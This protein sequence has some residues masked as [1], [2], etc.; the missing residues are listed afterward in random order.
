[1][2]DDDFFDNPLP[3]V[4]NEE[5]DLTISSKAMFGIEIGYLNFESS[6]KHIDKVN[7]RE[8]TIV[9]TGRGQDISLV[10]VFENSNFM[11]KI[12]V[13]S[14]SEEPI[15]SA[16]EMG[17]SEDI[18]SPKSES[19]THTEIGYNFNFNKNEGFYFSIFGDIGIYS[20]EYK[21]Q[22]LENL[23]DSSDYLMY[24]DDFKGDTFD[25]NTQSED[26]ETNSDF[27]LD[28][29]AALNYEVKNF[30]FQ[31]IGKMNTMEVKKY[32]GI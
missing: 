11:W 24:I 20:Y 30:K 19:I 3:E 13:I 12:G 27:F 22:N 18:W 16:N 4:D 32:E 29:G 2:E 1:I 7:N 14:F 8:R 6:T 15:A 10:Y 17:Y 21:N 9:S 23:A 5:D 28:F 26:M 31:I 25:S